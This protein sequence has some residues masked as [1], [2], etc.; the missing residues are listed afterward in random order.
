MRL[1]TMLG[2]FLRVQCSCQNPLWKEHCELMQNPF[3]VVSKVGQAG[4]D[5]IAV[6]CYCISNP[7]KKHTAVHTMG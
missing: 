5:E 7:V 6:E 4:V 3:P 1:R 2:L